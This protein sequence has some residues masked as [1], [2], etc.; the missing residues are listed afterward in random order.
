MPRK[1]ATPLPPEWVAALRLV[2]EGKDL[3]ANREVLTQL[4]ETGYVKLRGPAGWALTGAGRRRI[5]GV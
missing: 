4:V 3:E 5:E 1:F 2:A